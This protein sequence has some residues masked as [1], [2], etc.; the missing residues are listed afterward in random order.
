MDATPSTEI[1]L[2]ALVENPL[3]TLDEII[4]IYWGL[5]GDDLYVDEFPEVASKLEE[6]SD[7]TVTLP[8]NQICSVKCVESIGGSEGQGEK[9]LRVYAV[10]LEGN[11]TYIK[12][13]GLYN[14]YSGIEWDDDCNFVKP[15]EVTVT[16][17]VEL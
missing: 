9:V 14:S 6:Q 2:A 10:S 11:V 4:L 15:I 12:F 17:Y 5:T 3:K 8:N 7:F 13:T 16:K 1:T